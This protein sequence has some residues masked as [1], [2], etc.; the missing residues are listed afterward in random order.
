MDKFLKL[1]EK[2]DR[3]YDRLPAMDGEKCAGACQSGKCKFECCTITGCTEKEKRLINKFIKR[4]GLEFPLIKSHLE[5]NYILPNNLNIESMSIDEFTKLA[6]KKKWDVKCSYLTKK[7]CG[8]YEVRPAI[9]RM[10]GAIKQMVC[11][12]FPE[13]ARVNIPANEILVNF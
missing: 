9:C 1:K 13:E 12:Y 8:I 2:M 5:M 6:L 10:F 4:E 11:P 3:R 7:G